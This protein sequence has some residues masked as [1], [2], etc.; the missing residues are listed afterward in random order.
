[1]TEATGGFEQSTQACTSLQCISYQAI[2]RHNQGSVESD[3]WRLICRLT[4]SPF[5]SRKDRNK[6]TSFN[7]AVFLIIVMSV[8]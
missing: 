4:D 3:E 6:L 2:Y 5:E 7:S 1:M 8:N